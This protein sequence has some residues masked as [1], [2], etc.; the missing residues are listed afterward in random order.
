MADAHTHATDKHYHPVH[1]TSTG[2][3]TFKLG[4]WVFLGSE[5]LFFGSLIA[6]Y[7]TYKNESIVGPYPADI[8]D[9]P[10]TSISTFVLLMSSLAMV[11]ALDAVQRSWRKGALFWIMAVCVLG[12]TF[13]GFQAYE[14]TEFYHHG[15]KLQTNLFGSTFFVLTGFH[16]AHVTLGTIML[17]IIWIRC[18]YGHFS[19]NDHF[20]FEAVA[21]YWHFVDVVW[22]GLFLFVY[23]L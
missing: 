13:L 14:F 9:I 6:T 23:V 8:L 20:A 7:M 2:L 15:L 21:W 3:N 1:R 22:L 12:A 17:A 11:L 4:F 16:G 19:K 18:F 5:C 10:L